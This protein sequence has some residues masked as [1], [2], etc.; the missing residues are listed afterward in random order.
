M[1]CKKEKVS[2]CGRGAQGNV[3]IAKRNST[4]DLVVVKIGGRSSAIKERGRQFQEREVTN[5]KKLRHPHIVHFIEDFQW[6]DYHMI[7]M[8]YVQGGTME[9]QIEA[10]GPM[11]ETLARHYFQQVIITLKFMHDQGIVHRD[12]KPANLLLNE[13]KTVVKF[14]DMGFSKNDQDH[15]APNTF[16]GTP[17][18]IAPELILRIVLPGRNPKI[19]DIREYN[20]RAV[21]VWAAGVLLFTMLYGHTPFFNR[22][23]RSNAELYER[24]K[25][26]MLVIPAARKDRSFQDIPLSTECKVLLQGI[27]DA[28]PETRYTIGQIFSDPWFLKNLPEDYQDL[29]QPPQRP[30]GQ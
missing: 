18:C 30:N 5:M 11:P 14:C 7:V 12:I 17:Q 3:Y 24:I 20:A 10:Y 15:S 4:A 28:N 2:Q 23:D 16:L 13:A 8:E 26:G 27:L 1:C 6:G 29:L 9:D 21:D 25:A 19:H 22:N